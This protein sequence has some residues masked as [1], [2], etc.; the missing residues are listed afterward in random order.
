VKR[1][2]RYRYDKFDENGNWLQRTQFEIV[3]ENGEEKEK[4]SQVEY[5][6]IVYFP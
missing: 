5:R 3:A 2:Y 1:R 4:P 6:S